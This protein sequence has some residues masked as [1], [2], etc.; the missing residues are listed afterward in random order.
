MISLSE[1]DT[2]VKRATKAVGFS[3]GI[4]EEVG[5]NIS[6][7]EMFGLPGLRNL[8][9]YYKIYKNKKFQ[10]ISLISK[11]NISKISYCPIISG[12]NFLDQIYALEKMSEIDFE[13]FAFPILFIPFLSRSSEI[14]GKKIFLKIDERKF[15]L[16]FN[17]SIFSN[18]FEGEIVEKAS[19]IKIIFLENENTFSA[20]DWKEISNLSKETFVDETEELKKT[21][22]GAGLTDND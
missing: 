15:L 16:N 20:I 3:W 13:N 11:S 2:T 22:A 18:N 21:A 8:N 19:K 4:A 5:K 1:I 17:Q 6:L 12:I 7:L 14:V 10:N 9:Q